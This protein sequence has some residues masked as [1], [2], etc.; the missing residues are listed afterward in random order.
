MGTTV[1]VVASAQAVS[2]GAATTVAGS[3]LR[4]DLRLV[5][6]WIGGKF[7]TKK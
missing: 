6:V 5:K 4:K 7:N 3:I 1:G 2:S